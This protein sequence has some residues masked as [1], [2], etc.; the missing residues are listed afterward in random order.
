MSA[1]K[2]SEPVFTRNMA[3]DDWKDAMVSFEEIMEVIVLVGIVSILTI[4]FKKL[5]PRFMLDRM[6]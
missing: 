6:L 3:F 5:I 4:A 2:S 1:D